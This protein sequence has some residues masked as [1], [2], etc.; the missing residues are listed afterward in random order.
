M[1]LFIMH[2]K[3]LRAIMVIMV[4]MGI[5]LINIMQKNICMNL[6]N[7]TKRINLFHCIVFLILTSCSL[8]PGMHMDTQKNRSTGND[9]VFIESIG[10]TIPIIEVSA[11]SITDSNLNSIYRIGNGDEIVITVWG[12][13]DIFPITGISPDQNRR[14]VDSNGNIYFPFVGLV[15]A[16]G[17][18][19]NELRAELALKL[20]NS[21][22]E[23]Q[24]DLS[25]AKFNSKKYIFLEK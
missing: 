10:K 23:P 20:S 8:S 2:M 13:P 11:S 22:T 18:T 1:V 24:L 15:Q 25:I 12:I 17:K 21:F 4:F 14:R 3:N 19:Q 7:M 16:A 9:E 5:M 6:M